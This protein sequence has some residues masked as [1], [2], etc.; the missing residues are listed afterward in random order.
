MI[1]IIGCGVM[2]QCLLRGMLRT[3]RTTPEDLAIVDLPAV[4]EKL[5][6]VYPQAQFASDPK[7]FLKRA[8]PANT[9][10]ILAIKPF[11][12]DVLLNSYKTDLANF[13]VLTIVAGRDLEYYGRNG[14]L[15]VVRVMTNIACKLQ[16]APVVLCPAKNVSS[17]DQRRAE[18]TLRSVGELHVIPDETKFNL[19]TALVG[20]APAFA[21]EAIEGLA[22]GAVRQ[23]LPRDAA[24]RL[25]AYALLGASKLVLEECDAPTT[26]R[27]RICTPGGCT[28][29]GIA[30]LES[31]AFRHALIRAL[32]DTTDAL[33]VKRP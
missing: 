20:S 16:A 24:L 19:V 21:L 32:Q 3:G 29:A 12:M 11:Q 6:A 22:L 5:R 1:I 13:L 14:L 33:V 27:D 26:L 8:P 30:S 25:A 28:I 17:D 18:D 4:Q 15:N 2:G 7:E 9:L 10:V 31:N 23:G